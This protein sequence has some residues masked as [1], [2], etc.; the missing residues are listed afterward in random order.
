MVAKSFE[1][2]LGIERHSNA[3]AYF[4]LKKKMIV[5]YDYIV[6]LHN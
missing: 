6:H 2:V 1:W 3:S 4:S 5:K